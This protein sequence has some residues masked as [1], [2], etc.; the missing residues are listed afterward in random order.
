[1]V[2]IHGSELMEAEQQ[3][4]LQ[5]G[6]NSLFSSAAGTMLLSHKQPR[7]QGPK[8]SALIKRSKTQLDGP[9]P[10]VMIIANELASSGDEGA[11]TSSATTKHL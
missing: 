1:M 5:L 8:P 4:R 7:G 10:E 11:S 9:S 6:L 3:Q 2:E